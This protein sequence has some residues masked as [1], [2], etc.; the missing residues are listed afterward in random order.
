MP[1]LARSKYF[2]KSKKK[3]CQTP[4]PLLM[5][6]PNLT[7]LMEKLMISNVFKKLRFGRLV[8]AASLGVPLFMAVTANAQA[9]APAADQTAEAERVVVTGS[10]IPTAEE[11]R[12][13]PVD[14]ISHQD[15]SITGQNS[16]ILNVLTKRNPDFV[17]V[18]NLGSSNANI[19]SGSTQGGSSVSIRGLPTLVLI[20]DRRF[21][22]SAAIASGGLVF[23]DVSVIPVRLIDHVDVLKDGAS[24]IY[25]S[26]AVG[27][28]V[29]IFMRDN[30][31][32]LEV[33]FHYGDTLQSST[34]ERQGWVLAGTGNDTTHIVAG[35][36]V[37]ESDPLFQSDRAY[38]RPPLGFLGGQ[39][40]TFGGTGRDAVHSR[41]LIDNLIPALW[42]AGSSINSPLDVVAPHSLAI[43][44]NNPNLMAQT[45]DGYNQLVNAGAYRVSSTAEVAMYDLSQKPTSTLDKSRQHAYAFFDHKICGDQLEAFGDFL[46]AHNHT[47]SDL[48][49]QPLSNSTGVRVP[50]A[51]NAVPQP[52][53]SYTIE[54]NTGLQAPYTPFDLSIDGNTV[55]GPF[56]LTAAN[57]YQ[58]NP[59]RFTND[60][61]FYRLLGGLKSQ[62]T[63]A[64]HGNW[65]A[66]GAVS[67]SHYST[68]FVNQNLVN[69]PV[70][71]ALITAQSGVDAMGNPIPIP[72]QTLDFFALDPLHD[73]ARSITPDTFS[74]IF[75]ST[76]R[77]QDSYLRQFD[78]VIRGELFNLPGGPVSIA[79]APQYYIEGFKLVDSPEI[80]IG[81]V[82][83]AN[84]NAGRYTFAAAGEL[85]IPIVSP[86]MKVP[87]IYSLELSLQGRYQTIEHINDDSKVPKVMLRYQPIKDLTFRG[88]FGNSFLAPDLFSLYGPQVQGFSPSISLFNPNSGMNEVQDQAQVISGSNPDLAPS[89]AQNWTAGV[90]YS[91]SWV[92]GKLT[93]LCDYFWTL[94]QNI[95]ATLPST[96]ILTSV[97][98][99]GPASQYAS[100][101]AFNNFPG[102]PGSR[103][104]TA[105]FQLVGNMA[106]VYYINN[107]R[108][109]GADRVEGWDLEA[110]YDMDLQQQFGWNLG[111]LTL[112]AKALVFQSHNRRTTPD[113]RYFN[114]NGLIGDEGFGAFPD[115]KIV[116][117][118][119]HRFHL[120]P[121]DFRLDLIATYIPEMQNELSGDPEFDDQNT[122]QTVASYFTLDGQLSYIFSFPAPEGAAQAPAMKDGKSVADKKAVVPGVFSPSCWSYQNWLNGVTLTVGC[123]NMLQE[124]PPIVQGGNSSTNLATYDPYGRFL[125]FEVVKKF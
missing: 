25:G 11:V 65:Y 46:F 77:R 97:N 87:F 31:Q 118:L 64:Q 94:Q 36:E 53:G 59:R 95:F 119:E 101:V 89:T 108:N 18:G 37:Y 92:P 50:S 110:S 67:Y 29:N 90:V 35:I 54:A 38:S 14:T 1:S 26:D 4:K 93:I 30:F 5:P 49:A 57:R 66:E 3:P 16:D 121:G 24:T 45:S 62:I 69:A 56:R 42:P 81:S 105:P 10:L 115:Y 79:L 19:A 39:T 112:D 52:D 103:P 40:T 2:K 9:P 120:G 73:G 70:L 51:F 86:E 17:G 72:G 23:Q 61:D 33:G 107:L 15:I 84:T 109:I 34:P 58:S 124:G 60:S 75:G 7:Q 125:Y 76:I 78:A 122:F 74:T 44:S 123:N 116:A 111:A 71:N 48:N 22:D 28:V 63:D 102:H 98:N 106:A 80:F 85:N 47:E 100:L 114:V 104:V 13:N 43:D 55:S 12:A 41:Y 96:T 83:T 68:D 8:L 32:G 117:T 27:G 6:T 113:S 21:A 88:T 99:L 91:P 82:P 20:E